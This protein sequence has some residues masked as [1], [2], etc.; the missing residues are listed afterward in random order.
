[1]AGE[2]EGKVVIHWSSDF[3]AQVVARVL[4]KARCLAPFVADAAHLV[5][6]ERFGRCLCAECQIDQVVMKAW[7]LRWAVYDRAAHDPGDED[8]SDPLLDQFFGV[9]RA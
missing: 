2:G 8:R 9:G 5:E 4:S 1:M 6:V 7:S 3:R